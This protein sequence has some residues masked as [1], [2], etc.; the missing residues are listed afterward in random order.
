MV[1]NSCWVKTLCPRGGLFLWLA[2]WHRG[3]LPRSSASFSFFHMRESGHRSQPS[4]ALHS[5]GWTL[6]QP[7]DVIVATAAPPFAPHPTS[8]GLASWPT[9]CQAQAYWCHACLDGR[10]ARAGRQ[11]AAHPGLRRERGSARK[12]RGG[13]HLARRPSATG[14]REALLRE[15]HS[16]RFCVQW[17][18]AH[19][20]VSRKERDDAQLSLHTRFEALEL[21]GQVSEEAVEGTPRTLPRA[22]QSTRPLKT[23]S[24]KKERRGDF[25]WNQL[26]WE[27][28]QHTLTGG[29]T[30]HLIK[31]RKE[32]AAMM[33]NGTMKPLRKSDRLFESRLYNNPNGA[34]CQT[35]YMPKDTDN[36]MIQ[37]AISKS[38]HIQ[39]LSNWA[40]SHF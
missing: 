21:E 23:A 16:H 6:Q 9:A 10:G 30:S 4:H 7:A 22:K 19:R 18:A 35:V 12:H 36:R 37:T 11:A 24:I 25:S 1:P 27:S 34:T 20:L 5:Q 2:K 39:I 8:P 32:A 15:S 38:T 28:Q 26:C 17:R 13:R 3:A 29:S 33:R 40:L 31:R 14:A